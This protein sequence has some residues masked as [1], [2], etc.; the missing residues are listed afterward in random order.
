MEN[1]KLIN[2]LQILSN[3]SLFNVEVLLMQASQHLA[4]E[5][6]T[7]ENWV[8]SALRSRIP[9]AVYNSPVR[10][11]GEGWARLLSFKFLIFLRFWVAI[12]I[13]AVWCMHHIG[14]YTHSAAVAEKEK[15][16][17]WPPFVLKIDQGNLYSLQFIK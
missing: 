10:R 4:Y 16:V 1:S 6:G 17:W 15:V 2:I 9:A 3:F 13:V 11:C 5:G 8:C 12:S 14:T 7:R